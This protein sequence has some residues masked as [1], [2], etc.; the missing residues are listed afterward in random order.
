MRKAVRQAK[1]GLGWTS[2]NPPVGCVIVRGGG[3]VSRGYHQK[4]GGPHAEVE[5]LRNL[6]GPA[7]KKDVLYVTLEPCNHFGRTPPCTEAIL[8]SGIRRVVVGA[9]DPNPRVAGG[10]IGYLKG[11]GLDVT[12]GVLEPECLRLIEPFR[13][14]SLTGLPFVAAKSALTLDGWTAASTGHSKWI[15]GEK[16]REHVHRLRG[17]M[18]A[19]MVGVGTVLGDDPSLTVRLKGWE[20][21]NPLRIVVD[22]HLRV[23][24]EAQVLKGCDSAPTLIAV[25][26]SV[27]AA[28]RAVIERPGVAILV[29]PEADGRVDLG[30]FLRKLGERNV[31][32][33]LLEGGATLMGAMIREKRVDKF[34][35][36]HAPKIL[37]G[38]DGIPMASGRGAKSVDQCLRLKDLRVR[39]FGEDVLF[40]GYP[41][42][43]DQ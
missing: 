33:V 1:K 39:R 2:P 15:T 13:K 3:V 42:Y 16:A 40:E 18:D 8:K 43:G 24:P 25:G 12:S 20:G 34:Y 22:T 10:G 4:A 6:K 38:G 19:V 36:F 9:R 28:R 21:R 11:K 30:V 17:R 26:E 14:H 23:H 7:K 29:C 37:G 41:E 31:T 32:S 5:A 35:L 27:P